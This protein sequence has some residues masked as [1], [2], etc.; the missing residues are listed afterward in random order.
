MLNNLAP[1]KASGTYMISGRFLKETADE[2]AIGLALIFQASLY[3]ANIL[4]K[5]RKA[6]VTPIFKGGN[7]EP[8]KAENYRPISLK[9]ITCKILEHIIHRNILFHLDQQRMLTDFQHGF[10]KSRSC[11]TQLIKKVTDLAKSLNEDQQVL[12]FSKP[13]AA[14]HR[15][16]LLKLQH[17]IITG[18][19]LKCIENF[20]KNRTQRV[21]VEDVISS[22]AQVTSGV[23]QGSV[24]GTLLF[25]VCINHS[26]LVD[27]STIGTFAD[28]TY[29]YRVIKSKEDS[30]ALQRDLDALV[31]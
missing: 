11:E 22:V 7:K 29:I 4:D 28:D 10:R 1:S 20:L 3:Q 6:I 14:C 13:F 8:S 19:N 27:S 15:Q 23:P 12:D 16:L 18:E 17:G 9:S 2:V 5:W 25:L 26:R 31:K 21:V 24:L 30:T